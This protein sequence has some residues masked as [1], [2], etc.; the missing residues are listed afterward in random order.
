M[1]MEPEQTGQEGSSPADRRLEYRSGDADRVPV[2]GS[3]I[4]SGVG[5]SMLLVTGAVIVA[6]LVSLAGHNAWSWGI[7]VLPVL[8][9]NV[10]AFAA[11]RNP[12]RRGLGIGLWIGFGVAALIEGAC[13]G[14]SRL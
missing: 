5:I 13:F 4:A 9:C 8:V 10:G 2:K 7:I 3:H 12:A 14:L 6:V 11:Y 1:S